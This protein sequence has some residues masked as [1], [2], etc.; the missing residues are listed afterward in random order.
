MIDFQGIFRDQR[1]RPYRLEVTAPHRMYYDGKVA[2]LVSLRTRAEGN[3]SISKNAL[4]YVAAAE[5]DKRIAE[6][7]IILVDNKW[8]VI[9]SERACDEVLKRIGNLPPNAGIWGDF[10]WV[11][12][13]L[14]PTA[15]YRGAT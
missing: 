2:V 1:W 7:Y 12:T 8:S 15:G 14:Q 13:A 11:D 4:A 6:G 10:W 3:W 9:A 5:H